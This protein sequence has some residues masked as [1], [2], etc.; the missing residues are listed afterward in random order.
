[1]KKSTGKRMIAYILT[2]IL[3][4]SAFPLVMPSSVQ[5]ATPHT[6][7]VD[8]STMDD[9]QDYFGEKVLTTENA[10][11]VWGDKSVFL[12]AEDFNNATEAGVPEYPISMKGSQDNFLVS[13]SAM[14]S[15]KSIVGYSAVPTDTVFV[16][17][18]SNS[19]S[20]E[21]MVSMVKAANAAIHKLLTLNPANNR[22]GVVVYS[23]IR[24][25]NQ[26]VYGL[27]ESAAVLLPLGKYKGIG[28][29]NATY[30]TYENDIVGIAKGVLANNQTP[31]KEAVGATYL[32]AGLQLAVNLYNNMK[33]DVVVKEGPQA[34]TVRMPVMVLMSDGAPT[35]ATTSINNVATATH[36]DGNYS[37]TLLSYLTQLT[38][39][40]AKQQMNSIYGRSPLFYT[41]GLNVGDSS[42]AR[43]VLDPANAEA[44]YPSY[45]SAYTSAAKA[46]KT[47]LSQNAADTDFTVPVIQG[48]ER[49]YVDRY[50]PASNDTALINAFQSIVDQIII[51][52][53]YY[54]TMVEGGQHHLDGYI[55]FTDELG[56][57]MEVKDIK[58]L[59]VQNTLYPGSAIVREMKQG[60]FGNIYTGNLGN[61]NN[62]GLAFLDAVEKRLGCTQ[63]QAGEVV[64]QALRNGQ[65]YYNSETDFSNYIGWYADEQGNF[66]GFWNGKDYTA[67]PAGAVYANKSY[68]FMGKVG[69]ADEYNETDMLH[70]S[71]QV[72]THIDWQHQVVLYKIPAALIPTVQYNIDFD[73]DT[74]ESG[75]NFRMEVKGAKEALRLIYEAGLKEDI[76]PVT[77]TAKI[78]EYEKQT[79]E[80][81]PYKENGV[82]H[83][84]SNA[85]QEHEHKVGE[86]TDS[87]DAA[88]LD[89]EP[90]YENERYY[91]TANSPLY[92]LNNHTYSLVTANP[93]GGNQTYYTKV[94]VF[95]TKEA[96]LTAAQ[97]E[98]RYTPVT[99]EALQSAKANEK[100]EYYI[101]KGT[102]HRLMGVSQGDTYHNVKE[103]EDIT[104]PEKT[105]PTQSLNYASHPNAVLLPDGSIHCDVCL[106]NNGRLT[107][108]SDQGIALTK[109]VEVVGEAV[110]ISFPFTVTLTPVAGQTLAPTYPV[111][112]EN[113]VF[114]NNVSMDGNGSFTVSLTEGQKV[115]IVN[116][117][118]G[119]AY[120][121]QE[122]PADG[123]KVLSSQNA[124]GTV[125]EN[126][127]NQVS[128]LNGPVS[129]GNLFL[130]KEVVID[131]AAGKV[132]YDKP[133]EVEVAFAGNHSFDTVMV[134]G[135][136][137]AVENGK[138]KEN[139]FL[140][141][142]QTVLISGVPE[143]TNY[144]VK[145]VNLPKGWQGDKE[146][147]TGTTHYDDNAVAVITNTYTPAMPSEI[148]IHHNGLKTVLGREFLETDSF[149]FRFEY[150]DGASWI[151]YSEEQTVNG[152]MEAKEFSF[153]ELLHG[154]I[155]DDTH[156]AFTFSKA[157]VYQFRVMENFTE[158]GGVN[159]DYMPKRFA[160]EIQN[161]F[162]TGALELVN[163]TTVTPAGEPTAENPHPA[164]TT[165]TRN[166]QG[167]FM[168][169]TV[170]N[171]HYKTS[172]R[173]AFALNIH[174]ELQNN[175]NTPMG[176][177]G[178]GFEVYQLN[179]QGEK[180][181]SHFIG[182]TNGEGYLLH[183]EL[184][185]KV[186]PG[187]TFTYY[188]AE[189]AGN[190]EGMQY[191]KDPVE[192][193]VELIDGLDG[194]L[195][196]V[197]NGEVTNDYHVTFVNVYGEE[198]SQVDT[199]TDVPVD[200]P[201]DTPSQPS[202]PSN[203]PVGNLPDD[204]LPPKT[205]DGSA[206]GVFAS[207]MLLTALGFVTCVS[208]QK[209]KNNSK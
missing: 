112:N 152:K 63:T 97:L 138:L 87:H 46:G 13:L 157:G 141:A 3:L 192:L 172:N 174:K 134:D 25:E 101:P 65:L 107:L 71:V 116:L 37:T 130:H 154:F 113:G 209:R 176:L 62:Q 207:V 29:N 4:I 177:N 51:Q 48:L 186:A 47:S 26:W 182:E 19:M 150:F 155:E 28:E 160:V 49:G 5:A 55:T 14:A 183:H 142:N 194:T 84:Y 16:L 169:T 146:E 105:H 171:N 159:Y 31:S 85:W 23:G 88:Y 109:Q 66:M 135:Q 128:F 64:S 32:Q 42:Y 69:S 188:V 45:W 196:T 119:T 93:V 82:Y 92:E 147:Y 204:T 103:G 111:Y 184:L 137:K 200:T 100:G 36:G 54:P 127:Y 106:G 167:K 41:L 59:T 126:T 185:N 73:G 8:A 166:E 125:A 20:D 60:T 133:F 173:V 50:F 153:D 203:P 198:N 163:V 129:H 132:T 57:F 6:R 39:A 95:V 24:I 70:I 136:P 123:W 191:V 98:Y 7:V 120:S 2:L 158:I 208:I 56:L 149:S 10:G 58:G 79:G 181:H 86:L 179:E 74:L 195:D 190:E 52:S 96:G 201:T 162:E 35:V 67:R 121:V 22:I 102:V 89:F 78:A 80:A 21:S 27:P 143:G 180:V 61:L 144:T 94:A 118:T 76:N 110:G 53:K 11:G 124:T 164:G 199:P 90:S 75:T 18:L 175:T 114:M 140:K 161:N 81:Y 206:P 68:G 33:N 15:N 9:W 34:G 139:L 1:M 202:A 197:I 189:V 178:F 131:E 43:G 30:L 17:D 168:I 148:N 83:F 156:N 151:A 187:D 115:Y 117:P 104:T 40:W 122:Q 91:F 108:T 193:K 44:P 38:A 77:V 145:E 165:V 170:F 99:A 12:S 205:G 72:R